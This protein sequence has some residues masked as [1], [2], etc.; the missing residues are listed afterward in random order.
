MINSGAQIA[1]WDSNT[2]STL[3]AIKGNQIHIH[4]NIGD[5]T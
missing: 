5:L 4:F 2:L 3:N 1:L